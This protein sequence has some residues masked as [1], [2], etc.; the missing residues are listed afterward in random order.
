MATLAQAFCFYYPIRL[1]IITPIFAIEET[2]DSD[3]TSIFLRS[4]FLRASPEFTHQAYLL[5]KH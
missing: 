1:I 3:A 5:L 4:I 2:E